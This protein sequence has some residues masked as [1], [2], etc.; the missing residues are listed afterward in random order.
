MGICPVAFYRHS[1]RKRRILQKE[2][3]NLASAAGFLPEYL[4]FP[5]NNTSQ[6]PETVLECLELI[7]AKQKD[8][9]NI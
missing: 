6:K 9:E 5:Q 2:L 3:L 7:N 4:H 1:E 8:L